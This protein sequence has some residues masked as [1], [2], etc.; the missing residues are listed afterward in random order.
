MKEKTLVR[1]QLYGAVGIVVVVVIGYAVRDIIQYVRFFGTPAICSEYE[2]SGIIVGLTGDE[3]HG[4]FYFLPQK[5][6]VYDLFRKEGLREFAEFRGSDLA[7]AL[8]SG[9]RVVCDRIRYRLTIG[10]ITIPAR[11]A[12]G[13]PIDLNVATL[14]DLVLIPGIGRKTASE[15]IKVREGEGGFPR[16]D[17]L[18]LIDCMGAKRYNSI[19]DYL[20]IRSSYP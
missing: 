14:E 17:S 9:D 8:H 10:D 11:L 20:Y 5:A 13:M 4:G 18:K 16:V 3:N 1:R 12:L 19:K 6:T 15:I 2:T 7:T